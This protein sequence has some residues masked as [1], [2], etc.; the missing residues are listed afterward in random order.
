MGRNAVCRVWM[1]IKEP[2]TF[3]V[4]VEVCPVPRCIAGYI[5]MPQHQAKTY[6]GGTYVKISLSIRNIALNTCKKSA[7]GCTFE[8]APYS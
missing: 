5:F 3:I 1:H 6:K 4:K 2:S 8:M 7:L